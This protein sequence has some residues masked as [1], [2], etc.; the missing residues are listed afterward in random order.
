MLFNSISYLFFLPVMV[1]TYYVIPTT[2]GRNIWLLIGSYYFYMNWNAAYALLLLSATAVTYFGGLVLTV[3]KDRQDGYRKLCL[4]ICLVLNLGMLCTFKYL[5]MLVYYGNILLSAMHFPELSLSWNFVLPVGISFFTLQAIGYLIDV[6]REDIVAE[7][8]FIT[9]A[10][11]VSFF[12]QLVAGPIERS[13]NLLVQLKS[14]KTFHYEYFQKGLLWILYGLMLKM[15]IADNLSI[16]V[17]K[18]FA[19]PDEYYGWYIVVA[20]IAFTIQI[21]CD[22]YG[23]S[24]IA[25]GSAYL[26]GIELMSNFESPYFSKSVK[27]FWRRWHISL[28]TW[29][30]DYLYIPLGGNKKG[31]IRKNINLLIVFLVSGLWHGAS[32]S[33]VFWGLLHGIYQIIG[34][35]KERIGLAAA[36]KPA[37]FCKRLFETVRTFILVTFAW[38]PFRARSWTGTKSIISYMVSDLSN[39]SILNTKNLFSLWKMMPEKMANGAI[40][41]IVILGLVD[42]QKY[43]KKPVV[44]KIISQELWFRY[45]VYIFL[46]LFILNYGCYGESYNPAQF[47]YFQF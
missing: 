43:K 9:Y 33:F 32:I 8:N 26:L 15:V 11:F 41:G 40:F 18:I 14:Q 5:T 34:D 46:V 28:S 2:K 27:E 23:Y 45:A 25:K 7:R 37:L 38:I 42:Y 20:T 31:T 19:F 35:V 22:F 4:I 29:F 1:I 30:R 21:Y 12:P 3:L 6:Y 24:I 36:T 39:Y 17:D 10:L 16:L 44:D 13:K 47:I